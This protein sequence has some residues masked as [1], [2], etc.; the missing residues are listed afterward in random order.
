MSGQNLLG[1]LSSLSFP[2]SQWQ[3]EVTVM[4]YSIV[5]TAIYHPFLQP[6][7]QYSPSTGVLHPLRGLH[8][9]LVGG[10]D[11]ASGLCL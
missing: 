1:S 10:A 2:P 5:T 3:F 4:V 6:I 11:H 9:L 8:S 7:P